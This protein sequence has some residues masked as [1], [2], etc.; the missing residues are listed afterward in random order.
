MDRTTK[1]DGGPLRTGSRPAQLR[2]LTGMRFI[3][4][5]MVFAFHTGFIGMYPGVQ[6]T[7]NKVLWQA[8]FLGVGFFFLLSGFVLTWSFRPSDTTRAFWRRRIFKI[9]PNH[10][11][12][13]IAAALLL[14]FV[15]DVVLNGRD[16]ILN[17][18]LLQAW[19]PDM[20][21]RGNY[22]GVA[23]S[24]SCEL[25]FYIS[26]PL[27]V[28][29]IG[30]IRPNRL[31]AWVGALVAVIFTI[32]FLTTL[33]PSAPLLDYSDVTDLEIWS[34]YQAPLPRMLDFTVGILLARIVLTGQRLPL[35]RAGSAVLVA[36]AY[37][38]SQFVPHT[39]GL[40]ALMVVPLGLL[41]AATA[42]ADAEGKK[43][44][45]GSRPMVWLGDV[46]FAFYMWHSLLLWYG[47]MTV[48]G[49]ATTLGGA[50]AE[51]AAIF[52]VTLFVAWLQYTLVEHPIMRRFSVS[53]R[54]KE[55]KAKERAGTVVAI[56]PPDDDRAAA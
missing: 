27:V 34:I 47:Y 43:S 35:G 5:F 55:K 4:A 9:F 18:F 40:V 49:P 56:K 50:L 14:A 12:T 29:W 26:F 1:G 33:F 24:L 28:R 38:A 13:F 37:G 21:V 17:V 39:F 3:A 7:M 23:W 8:G 31:W 15:D 45:L 53:K 2:S 51:M 30:K 46:S 10:L 54:D 52:V 16:A 6:A 36:I 48:F 11:T 44:W 20:N 19:A 25:L 41:I 42:K 32:P 22:N